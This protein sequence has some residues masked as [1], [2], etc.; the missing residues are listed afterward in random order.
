MWLLSRMRKH[1]PSKVAGPRERL[2]ARLADMWLLYR[3]RHHVNCQK[4]CVRECL[5]ALHVGTLVMFFVL[6]PNRRPHVN[7]WSG[8]GVSQRR[9]CIDN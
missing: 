1:V 7:P 8:V 9:F 5:A 2:V 3:T 4:A 6:L